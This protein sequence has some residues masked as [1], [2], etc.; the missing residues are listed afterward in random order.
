MMSTEL[1]AESVARIRT[2]I[3]GPALKA[4]AERLARVECRNIT[5][6]ADDGP[7]FWSDAAG[8]LV[9]DVDGNIFVDLTAGFGVAHAGHANP[10]VAHAVGAQMVALP[11]ALGDVH[12][13]AVKVEL[14]EHLAQLAPG[15]LGVAILGSAGAEAV[16]A[17]LKTALLYTGRPGIVAFERGYHGLTYG[18]LATTARSDFRAP[19]QR[20]LFDGVRFAPFPESRGDD[21]RAREAAALDRLRGMLE[22]ADSS[23]TPIGCVLVEPIQGRGGIVVPTP[24]FLAG[25]RDLCDGERRLLVFDEIYTGFGRTGHWFACEHWSV[26]PDILCVGKALTGGLPLSAAIGSP[27][28]MSAWPRSR[29]EAIHTST[30]LG[31]PAAC[32]AALAQLHEIERRQLLAAATRLGHRI[33]Q[34]AA[35]WRSRFQQVKQ[36]RGVGLL[37]A[38]EMQEGAAARVAARAQAAGVL[39]LTEGE[40]GEVLAITPPAVIT[41]DQLDFALNVLDSAIAAES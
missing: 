33:A 29:G 37:Q 11:H 3:P 36:C 23:D 22:E 1:P 4:L 40:R 10:A 31:N 20:Q 17:A 27:R 5:R 34:R 24:G 38:V 32:A 39:V 28:T 16:E 9:R 14:L 41:D 8:A 35:L 12:P 13:A 30:F 25:L 2:A 21:D 18:A 6:I 26:V 19:F 15:E 7:V